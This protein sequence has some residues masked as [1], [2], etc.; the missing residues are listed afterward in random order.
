MGSGAVEKQMLS[1]PRPPFLNSRPHEGAD[2]DGRRES[3]AAHPECAALS[4]N[5]RIH[6]SW[7]FLPACP[8]VRLR[9]H[10]LRSSIGIAGSAELKEL[11]YL[12]IWSELSIPLLLIVGCW[13]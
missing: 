12:L 13:G 1:S 4:L 2:N 8:S 10:Q 6:N 9:L 7:N 3:R 11:P 5:Q